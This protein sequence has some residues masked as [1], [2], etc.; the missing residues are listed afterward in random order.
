M[1]RK[2]GL[3]SQGRL[4]NNIHKLAVL[5][6]ILVISACS[7]QGA[8]DLL[9]PLSGSGV[10]QSDVDPPD[11]DPPV[12]IVSFQ[13]GVDGYSG[14]KD[15]HILEWPVKCDNNT[16]AHD[17]IEATRNDAGNSNDDKAIDLSSIPSTATVTAANLELFFIGE[18]FGS[19]ASK[20]L[21]VHRITGSWIEG[22]GTGFDGQNVAGVDWPSKPS[23]DAPSIDDQLIGT[24]V[25]TWYSFSITA[26]AQSW[27]SNASSNYGVILM[28]DSPSASD[29]TKDFASSE[30]AT[31]SSRPKLTV[32]Y[33][34]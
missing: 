34:E 28:E 8:W 20:T 33:T 27:V 11:V 2:K 15:A 32:S 1:N 16:G 24:D 13:E 12:V 4:L 3:I 30:H 29:G 9:G 7:P 19:G 10:D 14:T 22:T 26:T 6:G 5:F 18:R 23:F 21:N 25:D 31:L 17:E